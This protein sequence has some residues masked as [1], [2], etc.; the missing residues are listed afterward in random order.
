[1]YRDGP[2]AFRPEIVADRSGGFN[3][4][5]REVPDQGLFL[6]RLNAQTQVIDVP[7]PG[8][9]RISAP[10]PETA[11]NGDEIDH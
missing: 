10:L 9:R 11:I 2:I 6:K 7:R 3:I 5:H 8:P 4:M 1:M